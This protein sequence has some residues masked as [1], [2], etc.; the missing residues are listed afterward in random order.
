MNESKA[1]DESQVHYTTFY[2]LN[3][4]KK[5]DSRNIR[6]HQHYALESTLCPRNAKTIGQ[7]LPGTCHRGLTEERK[8]SLGL[9]DIFVL[10]VVLVTVTCMYQNSL[11]IPVT[12]E[13]CS[14]YKLHLN[15]PTF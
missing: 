5:L 14:L 4:K 15:K 2:F 7:E 13:C 9:T 6:F 8:E 11:A 10:I 1:V 12:V 3:L